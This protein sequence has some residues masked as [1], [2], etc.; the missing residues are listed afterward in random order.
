MN[1]LLFSIFSKDEISSKSKKLKSMLLN[2][3]SKG[4]SKYTRFEMFKF[5]EKKSK[6]YDLID[7]VDI[8][9]SEEI[10]NDLLTKFI[11]EK[12]TKFD[13]VQFQYNNMLLLNE[14]NSAKQTCEKIVSTEHMKRENG[15]LSVLLEAQAIEV[16]HFSCREDINKKEF[17]EIRVQ[18]CD[19]NPIYLS[20]IYDKSIE[21][22]YI[23]FWFD[24]NENIDVIL[25]ELE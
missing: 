7:L 6:F 20:F 16:A 4:K 11:G 24:I 13:F 3:A 23:K 9:I 18:V 17:S 1:P 19:R 8:F 5:N 10:Y 21:K 25:N 22:Y 2:S 15:F 14:T 12:Q